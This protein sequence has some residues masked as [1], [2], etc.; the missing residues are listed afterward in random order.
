MSDREQGIKADCDTVYDVMSMTKQFTAAAIVKLESQGRLDVSDRIGEYLTGVPDDKRG[1]TIRELLTH[2]SGLVDSLGGD[3]EPLTREQMIR[4]ALSSKL[5]SEPGSKYSYSN[6][7][8]SL[9]AAI[10][11]KA[12]GQGYEDYLADELFRPAGMDQTGYVLP[13]WSGSDVAVEYDAHGKPRGTP[14]E[15]PWA[16]DGPYWNL[17]GNGGMLSTPRDMLRWNRALSGSR[18][19]DRRARRELFKPRV[20]EAP[21]PTYYAYGWVVVDPRGERTLWHNGSD[22]LS[23]GEIARD[24]DGRRFVFWVSN[25]VRDA[26]Q[27]WN[28]EETGPGFTTRTF[29]RLGT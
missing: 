5:K 12:S 18:I 28:L 23:Y 26:D 13:D 16:G 22:G 11:E 2:T 6:L 1:I 21:D 3:Y 15:R 20:R 25:Q 9:L 27:G 8:Y 24:P 7:G 29:R 4:Q 17:R 19:L 10:V 14:L